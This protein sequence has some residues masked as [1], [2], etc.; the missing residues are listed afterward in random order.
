MHPCPCCGNVKIQCNGNPPNRNFGSELVYSALYMNYCRNSLSLSLSVSCRRE[1]ER[2]RGGRKITQDS[3]PQR[4]LPLHVLHW[5]L[6][7]LTDFLFTWFQNLNAITLFCVQCQ[8]VSVSKDEIRY[9]FWLKLFCFYSGK[10]QVIALSL[11]IQGLSQKSWN[12]FF[13][14]SPTGRSLF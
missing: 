9:K 10:I 3:A 2:E 1:R 7:T 4:V 5:E 8:G 12:I 13:C 6:F 11:I 14:R